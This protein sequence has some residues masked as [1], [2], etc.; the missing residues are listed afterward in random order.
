MNTQPGAASQRLTLLLF[1]AAA[2]LLVY[3]LRPILTPFLLAALFAYLGN[4]LVLRL[5]REGRRWK[6]RLPRT[7]AVILVF[8]LLFLGLLLAVLTLV[9]VLQR[10]LARFLEWLPQWLAWFR[11]E[12]LPWLENRFGLPL[13]GPEMGTLSGLLSEH[14]QQAGEWALGALGSMG[15]SGGLVFAW[16]LNLVLVPVVTFYLLRDWER[17]VA[18]LHG[19]LPRSIEPR[20]VRIVR[21]SDAVLATF[22]R[23]QLLV[24]ISLAAFYAVGLWFAG[25][26]LA[27]AVGVTAGLV[28]FVP[29]L[30]VIVG[31]GLG[32]AAALLQST[33]PWLLIW[34]LAVF[35]VGQLLESLVLTPWLVGDRI[36]L[37]P[38]AV[39]FAVLAGGQLFGFFGVLLA[40]PAAAVLAVL[41]RHAHADYRGSA[42]YAGDSAKPGD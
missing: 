35:G 28:S 11:A 21:E 34:V 4:P 39:I 2:G 18:A 36:G 27:I 16:L 10:E 37:H 12:A 25:L 9:P 17:L 5:Q 42:L 15:R 32:V 1:F 33:D 14:W 6:W 8:L 3:W 13:E 22:I 40:L 29:Y 38:V 19:L 41:V 30:G 7:A 23:G 24:M 26:D 31:V 20:V